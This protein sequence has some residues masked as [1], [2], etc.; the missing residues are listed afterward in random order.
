MD[1]SPSPLGSAQ[2]SVGTK[3]LTAQPSPL[4]H[5]N[6]GGYPGAHSQHKVQCPTS[7]GLSRGSRQRL[8]TGHQHCDTLRWAGRGSAHCTVSG[9]THWACLP[10]PQ[11]DPEVSGF[12]GS[13]FE[14]REGEGAAQLRAWLTGQVQVGTAS[15]EPRLGPAP[16]TPGGPDPAGAVVKAMGQLLL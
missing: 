6:P 10:L 3:R 5:M 8:S 4:L 12:Q 11:K 9:P 1:T 7:E 2:A 15:P 16:P 14:V 13:G